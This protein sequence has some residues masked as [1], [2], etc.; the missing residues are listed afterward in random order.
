MILHERGGGAIVVDL[1]AVIRL[2]DLEGDAALQ[3]VDH[4]DVSVG[5]GGEVDRG[6]K[7]DKKLRPNGHDIATVHRARRT[8]KT[9]D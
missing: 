9:K 8:K 5:I 7:N 2:T 1:L 4:R 6:L 3:I